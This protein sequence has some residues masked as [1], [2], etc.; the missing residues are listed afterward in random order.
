VSDPDGEL[1]LAL[2]ISAT[3]VHYFVGGDGVISG[4]ITGL[5]L[6]NEIVDNRKSVTHP[7]KSV[8]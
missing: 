6:E 4:Q 2:G 8:Q 3:P 5:L 1:T 7:A